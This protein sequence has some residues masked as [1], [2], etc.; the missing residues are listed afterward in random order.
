MQKWFLHTFWLLKFTGHF[1]ISIFKR[2][3]LKT[4]L[5]ATQESWQRW[6]SSPLE[7]KS[8]TCLRE[9]QFCTWKGR[10]RREA[11]R[12]EWEDKIIT[13]DPEEV[14]SDWCFNNIVDT[15]EDSTQSIHAHLRPVT[16]DSS[17][18]KCFL[19]SIFENK[20]SLLLRLIKSLCLTHPPALPIYLGDP[21][22]FLEFTNYTGVTS[23]N[24]T[25]A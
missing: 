19:L 3:A 18:W 4:A 9:L 7:K 1:G 20:P 11:E 8:L 14:G 16:R 23:F 5:W 12:I 24:L 17:R 10:G 6:L 13:L 2:E 15:W 22:T 21:A 25:V